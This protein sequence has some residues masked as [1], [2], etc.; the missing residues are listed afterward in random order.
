MIRAALALGMI[1]SP[2]SA[3]PLWETLSTQCLAPMLT[4]APPVEVGTA[5][6]LPEWWDGR[7]DA[8]AFDLGSGATL[9]I[10]RDRETICAV[11]AEDAARGAAAQ[12]ALTN[13]A[14]AP[15]EDT[16]FV[17]IAPQT[18]ESFEWREP[19]LRVGFVSSPSGAGGVVYVHETD[20]EA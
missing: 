1:A 15:G 6:G 7:A 18:Y 3:A 11:G 8:L 13:W 14:R 2:L 10:S 12:A 4:L 17:E 16:P 19:R 9:V 5:T 20:L